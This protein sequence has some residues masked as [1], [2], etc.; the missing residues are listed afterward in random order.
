M[1][2]LLLVSMAL[3]KCTNFPLVI[4]FLNF[5]Q[6]I[7]TFNYNPPCFLCDLL[8]PLV[9]NDY[10][11]KETFSFVFQINNAN[12]FRKFLVSYN[13]TSLFPNI[14]LQETIDIAMHLIFTY[15]HNL[16]IIKKELQNIFLF[17]ISQTYFIF[18]GKFYNHIDGVAMGSSLTLVFA[19][20]S[21]GFYK[22]KWLNNLNKPNFYLNLTF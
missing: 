20:T 2:L 4:Y 3:L 5:V 15:N 16:N 17:A 6:S 14:T 13:V 8:S 9:S 21:M 10:S 22:S 11:C 12:L 7:G 18:N 19:N 1:V